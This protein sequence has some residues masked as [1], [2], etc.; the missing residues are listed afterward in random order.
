MRELARTDHRIRCLQRLGRRGLATACI[1]GMLA[2]AA[3]YVAVMDADLQH[4]ETILPRMLAAAEA[5]AEVVVASRYV[6]G[7]GT[8]DWAESRL[9]MS[10]LATRIARRIVKTETTDPMSG[11]FLVRRSLLEETARGLSGI[12]FKILLDIL[13]TARRPV[14]L[15]E[16]PYTF[17][18]RLHGESKLDETVLWQYGML[19]ADKSI[20]RYIP[21]RFLS[22]S[23]IGGM[24]VI[25]HM[26]V[27]GLLTWL[28]SLPFQTAQVIAT[29]IAM[30]FNFDLNNLLTYR[31]RRLRGLD[32][33][34]GLIA[35][36]L[37]CSIGA[38]ANIG[39]AD[40]V[41]EAR[42]EWAL[43]ALAGVLVGATWNYTVTRL[44][45]W[46]RKES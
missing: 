5:G 30:V 24:G 36:M 4:D 45:T 12:G 46:K 2:S 8:G 22:F 7:G 19:L 28:T 21:V 14:R 10:R 26:S 25:V 34:K 6:A 31:D 43:A 41:F 3:P 37:A 29:L 27:V 13:A 33:V 32:W 42:H 15:A 40:F 39:I 23:L 44:Y 11:F 20:G 18:N 17:R 16:V 1:E 9:R 35:F 38:V